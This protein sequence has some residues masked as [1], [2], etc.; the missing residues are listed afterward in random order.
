MLVHLLGAHPAVVAYRPFRTEPRVASYWIGVLRA[1]SEPASY[2]RQILQAQNLHDPTWWLGREGRLPRRTLDREFQDWL[3]SDAVESLAELCRSRI[4]AVYSRIADLFDRPDATYFTEKFQPDAVPELVWELYP[5]AR[6]IVLVRDFRDMLCSMLA[7]NAKRGI[8]G[9]GRQRADSDSEFVE[10]IG[11]AGFAIATPVGLGIAALFAAASTSALAGPREGLILRLRPALLGGLL[12]LMAAWAVVS[13]A[14][15]PPLDGPPPP[16]EGIGPLSILS[17]ISVGLYAFAAWRSFQLYRRRGGAVILGVAVAWVLLAE[18]MIAVSLSRNWRAS[19][20]EWHVLLLLAFVAI[21]LGARSEYRR[22]GSLSAAF[23]GLYLEAT[24]ARLDRW[25]AGAVASVVS[26]D[27]RG[28][29][30]DRVLTDLRREGA[31]TDEIALLSE[32]AR[33]VQRLDAAFRP[34]LPSVVSQGIRDDTPAAQQ[35][36]GEERE[37]SVV[38]ADLAAFTTFSETR[39]PSEVI[40]MLNEYWAA[41]VPVIDAAGGDI[42]HFAGDGVMAIFNAGGDQPD[43]ARRAAQ[44][45]LAIVRAGRPIATEHPDWPVFRVGVNTG[46]AVVGIVGSDTR[47]S[48][49]AIGDSINTAARL[50]AAGEPGDVVVGRSTWDALGDASGQ[51]LG[52]VRVKGKSTPVEAWRLHD[53]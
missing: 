29:S 45:G 51:P 31:S 36:G 7:F 6:E 27:A 46:P 25:F 17:L 53:R 8:Q 11:E 47:R 35:L 24:L 44:T 49:S 1:L 50:M 37:V 41:V 18:A 38:F 42:E 43:H 22:G 32:A 30:A 23:G 10:E 21:A 3:G 4:D 40:G 13:I 52:A 48:F 33:E 28:E 26:A 5:N 14:R 34:Y 19:W 39:S 2:R 15:L 20:W 9:F 16:L 12:A